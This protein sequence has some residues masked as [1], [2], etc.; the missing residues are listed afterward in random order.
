MEIYLAE[1]IVLF[2]HVYRK[3]VLYVCRVG[4]DRIYTPYMTVFFM[5]SLPKEPYINRIYIYI[6]IYICVYIYV[7]IDF[8]H[9][10]RIYI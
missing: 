4:Q 8:I 3:Y 1:N 10:H 7:Y 9:I 2:T 5:I 6:Y